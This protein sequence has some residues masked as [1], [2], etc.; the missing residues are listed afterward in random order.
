MK[1]SAFPFSGEKLELQLHK[2]F[3]FNI[4]RTKSFSHSIQRSSFPSW[5]GSIMSL[6]FLGQTKGKTRLFWPSPLTTPHTFP[7]HSLS[8]FVSLSQHGVLVTYLLTPSGDHS[9]MAASGVIS[10]ASIP[11]QKNSFSPSSWNLSISALNCSGPGFGMPV[12][13]ALVVSISKNV[14]R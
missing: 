13:R 8:P 11:K 12:C 6:L 5:F 14:H 3:L 9:L 2:R 1:S 7:S 4:Y 10:N